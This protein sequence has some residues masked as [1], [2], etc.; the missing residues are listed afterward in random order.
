[1]VDVSHPGFQE[2]IDVVQ[3]TLEEIG[4][5]HKP[6]LLVFNKIDELKEPYNPDP[7][8]GEEELPYAERLK[9]TWMAKENAPVVFISAEQKTNIE[10]LRKTLTAMVSACTVSE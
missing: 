2:Q 1:V 7:F 10:E 4:A 9:N 8:A 3:R 5:N 6:V